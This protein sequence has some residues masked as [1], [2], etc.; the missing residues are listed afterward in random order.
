MRV[1]VLMVE[2]LEANGQI[3]FALSQEMDKPSNEITIKNAME[4]AMINRISAAVTQYTS[5]LG[6]KR[7]QN[8][9]E[10]QD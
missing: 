7:G 1:L 6:G 5:S 10:D 4:N 9:E 3:I 8:D 2:A